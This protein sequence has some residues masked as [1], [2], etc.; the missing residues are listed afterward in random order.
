LLLVRR[1]RLAAAVLIA[2]LTVACGNGSTARGSGVQPGTYT[3]TLQ[4]TAG[5]NSQTTQVTL[6]VQ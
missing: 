2:A 3:L 6:L 5:S 4:G 1:T